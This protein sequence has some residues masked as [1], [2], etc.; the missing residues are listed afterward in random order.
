MACYLGF[1]GFRS[2]WV[3]AWI[4]D[5]GRHGFD[6]SGCLTRLLSISH[7]VAMIDIPIGLPDTGYRNCDLQAREWLG[8]SVFVGARRN[9]LAFKSPDEANNYYWK[10]EGK[11]FGISRQ[12]WCLRS[13]IKEVDD[14]M[15]PAR[16]D[17][18]RETHPELIFWSRNRKRKLE[19][20][21]TAAGRQQRVEMLKNLG[22]AAIDSWL[23]LR[24]HTGIGRDDLIDACA[25]AI[26]ARDAKLVIGGGKAD[27]RGLR[28][29]M[30]Y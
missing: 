9:L 26:A 1:D 19:G 7:K 22:F 25:C 14:L 21:K 29:E 18:L 20:K 27:S 11:G 4:D 2:G 12:L 6:Y 24:S 15:L 28:M 8:S 3:V 10:H 16:Q 13:K 17:Q 23:M 30:H 5:H